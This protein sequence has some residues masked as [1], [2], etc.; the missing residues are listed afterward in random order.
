MPTELWPNRWLFLSLVRREITNRYSGTLIGGVWALGQPVLLLSIYAFVFRTIFK[1]NFGEL[2]NHS[3]TA[4]VACALWPWMAFQEGVQRATHSITGN[5]GLV[6]KVQFPHEL[7]VLSS[8]AA[9]FLI[10]FVGFAIVLL[11]LELTGARFNY[12]ATPI[13]LFAWS[14]LLLLAIAFA[15]AVAALQVFLKDIDHLLGPLFMVCFYA[16]PILYPA[17]Q[18]PEPYRWIVTANPI[19]QLLNAIRGAL[20][21]NDTSHTVLLGML[22]MVALAIAML[23]H[24]LFR[25]LSSYFA[26]FV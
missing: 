8:V 1:V 26:D 4:F 24:A 12:G 16:T 19:A 14:I 6:R 21:F 7:L 10:H 3:F 11:A 17:T 9:T 25:R 2:E 15:L 5:V 22:A 13:V 23:S 20:L 18:V